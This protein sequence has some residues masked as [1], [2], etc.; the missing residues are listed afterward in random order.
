L[1]PADL[2]NAYK[3]SVTDLKSCSVENLGQGKFALHALPWQAQLAPL[4]GM[5]VEDVD[6]DGHPDLVLA[7]NDYGAEPSVGHADAMSGMVMLGDGKG[8]FTPQTLQ[9]SGF[10]LPGNAKA[11]VRLRCG[12][13]R[14][15]IAASQHGGPLLTFLKQGHARQVSIRPGDRYAYIYFKNGSRRKEEFYD[16]DSFLGQS[17]NFIELTDS[18]DHVEITNRMGRMRKLRAGL[19]EM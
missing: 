4:Y 9:R 6:G 5:K 13:D 10:Y 15:L 1:S 16:G 11:L 14:V 8:H 7:G 18:V 2:R 19:S 3:R 17:V 12:T